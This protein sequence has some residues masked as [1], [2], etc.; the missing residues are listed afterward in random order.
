MVSISFRLHRVQISHINAAELIGPIGI[1][2]APF[3]F[4]ASGMCLGVA[5]KLLLVVI[6]FE[7]GS[8]LD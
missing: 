2:Y 7:G 3:Y 8:I 6:S 1:V 5:R 4:P